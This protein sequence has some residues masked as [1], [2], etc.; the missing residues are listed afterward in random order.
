MLFNYQGISGWSA[1]CKQKSVY[2]RCMQKSLYSTSILIL[3]L[4]VCSKA[5]TSTLNYTIGAGFFDL[6]TYELSKQVQGDSTIYSGKSEVSVSYLL[7]RHEVIFIT[8]SEFYKDTLMTSHVEVFVNGKLR[9][10]NHTQF[11]GTN[12]SIYRVDEDK[13]IR[14]EILNI[15][16]IF[17]TSSML[18]F[19]EPEDPVRFTHNYAELYGYFN[20]LE[21]S[22]K[23]S[24]DII[25]KKTGR[26]TTYN[27]KKGVVESTEIDYPI[28]TFGHTRVDN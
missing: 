10:S 27:Y 13:N 9:E 16:A 2:F 8:K 3:M 1:Y 17:V 5:Q 20:K 21:R 4:A 7:S 15:P 19:V 28:M 24:Y 6:G 12:Y 26:K 23:N 14:D 11:E 22:D 18:F 25:D